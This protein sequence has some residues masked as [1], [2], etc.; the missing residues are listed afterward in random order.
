M[1]KML[2]AKSRSSNARNRIVG[3]AGRL[4]PEKGFDVLIEAAGL[5]APQHPEAS[6]SSLFGDGAAA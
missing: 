5:L 2:L 1:P 3:A 4:S 6:V